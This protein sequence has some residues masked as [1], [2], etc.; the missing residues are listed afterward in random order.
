MKPV[1]ENLWGRPWDEGLEAQVHG[2]NPCGVVVSGGIYIDN[3]VPGQA[4]VVIDPHWIVQGIYVC[5]ATIK[6][7][8]HKS[9]CP[10]WKITYPAWMWADPALN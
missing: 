9:I 6:K 1:M 2:V 8:P 3:P 4:V 10:N 5:M 7:P